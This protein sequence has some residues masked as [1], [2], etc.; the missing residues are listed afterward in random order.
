MEIQ[1][2]KVSILRDMAIKKRVFLTMGK[3]HNCC[4]NFQKNVIMIKMHMLNYLYIGKGGI[5]GD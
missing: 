4:R 1:I 5:H 2:G 3:N